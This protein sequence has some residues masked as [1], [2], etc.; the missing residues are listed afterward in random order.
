M[1]KEEPEDG[2]KEEAGWNQVDI[3]APPSR[4][5]RHQ[6]SLLLLCLVPLDHTDPEPPPLQLAEKK[7]LV[8]I[9]IPSFL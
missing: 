7:C 4:Q 8:D 6:G 3:H 5:Q 2:K 9:A 1:K